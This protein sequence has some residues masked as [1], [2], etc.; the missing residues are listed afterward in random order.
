MTTMTLE[1]TSYGIRRT[2]PIP[3]DVALARTH[4]ALKREGFGIIAEIDIP[5][6]LKE[7]LGIDFHRYMI[8]GACIPPLA[9]RA[10][11]AEPDIGLLLPCNVVVY[12]ADGETVVGAIDADAMLAVTD[13]DTLREVATE[14]RTRL[15]RVL[16]SL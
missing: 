10:L 7:K 5:A 3:Y 8:L 2:L 11:Q 4:E 13:N 1:R 6:K 15:E 12:E 9:H 16:E 14:V